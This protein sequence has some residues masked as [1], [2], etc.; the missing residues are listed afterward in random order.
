LLNVPVGET[1]TIR[2]QGSA[3]GAGSLSDPDITI[4]T[5]G[6]A[7]TQQVTGDPGSNAQINLAGVA[8]GNQIVEIHSGSGAT[9]TY[10]I[11][12]ERTPNV[13][14]SGLDIAG[15]ISS[16][17]RLDPGVIR[18]GTIDSAVDTDW[19]RFSVRD[20]QRFTISLDA[21]AAQAASSANLSLVLRNRDGNILN[22][23][24]P[25]A[26][27]TLRQV[28]VTDAG[29]YWLEIKALDG[30]TTGYSLQAVA[31][32][33]SAAA[34]SIYAAIFAPVDP[35]LMSALQQLA[36]SQND[37]GQFGMAVS[38]NQRNPIAQ[39]V[40]PSMTAIFLAS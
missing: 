31:Q 35:M 26:L 30:K 6:G 40:D 10:R 33:Q 25:N 21:L 19:F 34:A 24:D 1:Y 4:R 16:T 38:P 22:Q 15:N 20:G 17:A 32:S 29:D 5:I 36:G 18:T 9:G 14:A 39:A 13:D 3:T 27:G 8:A 11:T 37:I 23:S 7:I 12:V 2:V 28:N